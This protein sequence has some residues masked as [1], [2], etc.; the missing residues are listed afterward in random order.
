MRD[1]GI[2]MQTEDTEEVMEIRALEDWILLIEIE[3]H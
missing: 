3:H 2:A 1:C